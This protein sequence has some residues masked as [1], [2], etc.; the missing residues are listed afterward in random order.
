MEPEEGKFDFTWLHEVVD[1]LAD[2]GISCHIGNPYRDAPCLV[3]K[4]HPDAAVL[5]SAGIRT[6]HGGRRRC[7]SNNAAYQEASA[8]IVRALA[9]R[10]RFRPKC[11]WLAAG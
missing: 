4:K 8:V 3:L 1:R 11:D 9:K 5:N 6:S 7:C 10:I 2:A